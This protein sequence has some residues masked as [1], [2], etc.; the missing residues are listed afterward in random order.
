MCLIG[1]EELLYFYGWEETSLLAF[2]LR[3]FF[4]NVTLC[5]IA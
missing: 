1:K 3:F 5:R 2:I 4:F